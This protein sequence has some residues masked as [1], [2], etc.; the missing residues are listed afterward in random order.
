MM[1]KHLCR[2]KVRR[3]CIRPKTCHLRCELPTVNSHTLSCVLQ[4]WRPAASS[5]HVG[6]RFLREAT[7]L[8]Q[9]RCTACSLLRCAPTVLSCF[10][11][12]QSGLLGSF[13][14][15]AVGTRDHGQLGLASLCHRNWKAAKLCMPAGAPAVTAFRVS[16]WLGRLSGST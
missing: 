13:L 7:P 12:G 16:L 5:G 8:A 14:P 10:L 3:M 4:I 11:A 15:P 6:G 9:V 1:Y 2:G